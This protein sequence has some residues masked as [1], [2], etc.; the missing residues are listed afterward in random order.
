MQATTGDARFWD[1]AARKYASDPIK[2]LAGY[3]RTLDRCASYLTKDDVVLELGCGTGTT[4]LRVAPHVRQILATD[5]S[6]EMIAI[7]RDRAAQAGCRNIELRVAPADE[8]VAEA[9]SFD[10]VLAFNLLHLAP[11]RRAVI[12]GGWRALKPGGL[13]I[14]KTTCLAEMTSL[15][16]LAVPVM[17]VI[18]K[19]PSVVAFFNGGE[20]TK[21]VAASGFEIV[22][23]ARHGSERK[24][25]RLFLV[26]RK[27]AA[28]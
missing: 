9:G 23:T 27:P 28:S 5:I 16:R 22:E 26:A 15:I 14:S 1:R 11:D 12:E 8:A 19:A 4:A 7:A 21:E 6:A 10:A 24:D 13:F 2:D 25:P 17:R 18:G 20:L 3:E